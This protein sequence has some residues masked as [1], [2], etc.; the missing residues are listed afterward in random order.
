MSRSRSRSPSRGRRS[1]PARRYACTAPKFPTTEAVRGIP[2]LSKRYKD[3][4]IPSDFSR[5]AR[6]EDS[7]H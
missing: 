2:S 6:V 3:L 7:L 5:C 4:Y 1:S